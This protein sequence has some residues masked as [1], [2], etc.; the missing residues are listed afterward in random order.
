MG[1]RRDI[2]QCVI[3]GGASEGGWLEVRRAITQCVINAR[4]FFR[5]LGGGKESDYTMC[6]QWWV[7]G[8][9]VRWG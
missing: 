1:V 7:L 6:N 9:E 3:N 2:T 8:T 4:C 5:W